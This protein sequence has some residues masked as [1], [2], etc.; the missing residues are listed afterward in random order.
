RLNSWMTAARTI[1]LARLTLVV[2]RRRIVFA[3]F[4]GFE[5]TCGGATVVV[6]LP[7]RLAPAERGER[8]QN[9]S[10]T[11][12]AHVSRPTAEVCLT[13]CIR[14]TQ[15]HPETYIVAVDW[16]AAYTS[17]YQGPAS[18][19]YPR[20]IN[21]HRARPPAQNVLHDGRFGQRFPKQ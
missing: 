10:G 6:N 4:A 2:K 17:V 8:F 19:R 15:P 3:P 11:V 7:L 5:V 20:R 21:I 9:R 18:R 12:V 14:A 16:L 1:P 13:R